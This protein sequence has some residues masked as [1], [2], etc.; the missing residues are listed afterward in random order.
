MPRRTKSK[1]KSKSK[2]RPVRNS[3]TGYSFLDSKRERWEALSDLIEL[4]GYDYVFAAMRRL[5][6]FHYQ[7]KSFQ[8]DF[9]MLKR[10]LPHKYCPPNKVFSRNSNSCI[11]A[12]QRKTKRKSI[13]VPVRYRY[14]TSP[15]KVVYEYHVLPK[16][17]T[18]TTTTNTSTQTSSRNAETQTVTPA[19]YQK[20][21]SAS[22]KCVENQPQS[23]SLGGRQAF[24]DK[25]IAKMT[26]EQLDTYIE[27]LLVKGEWA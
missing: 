18:T 9:A 27:R 23:I 8:T 25:K 11:K 10:R 1:I 14:F 21:R 12:P 20:E 2:S 16:H 4:K 13:A 22:T 24:C 7:R 26:D 5:Q 6:P 17:S 3:L 19:R 15:S